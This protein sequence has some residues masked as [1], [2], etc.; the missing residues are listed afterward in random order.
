M[1]MIMAHSA[2][3]ATGIGFWGAARVAAVRSS[4]TLLVA[5]CSVSPGSSS[6]TS[7]TPDPTSITVPRQTGDIPSALAEPPSKGSARSALVPS[8]LLP[9]ATSNGKDAA[10]MAPRPAGADT[11][12]PPATPASPAPTASAGPE[13]RSS[14]PLGSSSVPGA[15]GSPTCDAAD[16]A[17][18]ALQLTRIASGLSEPTFAAAAPGDDTRL[19]VLERTG[20]IRVLRDGMLL[21][22]PFLNLSGRVLTSNESGLVGLAFHPRYADNGRFFVQYALL[23]P[24]QRVG[25]D[26]RV[27]LSEFRRSASNTD[28]ADA[29]SER[30][31][32]VVEQPA[33]M[34]LGGMLAFG[35]S[36]GML[37]VSRGEGGDVS[38]QDLHSLLG[39]MLRIDV[40]ATDEGRPYGIPAG[41]LRGDG[42]LPEIWSLGF[43]NP[44]RFA[45]DDCTNDIYIGDVGE[46]HV[47]ELDFEPANSP[48][49]NYG[50]NTLEGSRCFGSNQAC[51][52][53][54]FTPP[55]LE[56]EHA[57][58]G[59]AVIA[60]RVYRGQRIPALRG[61][62]LYADYCTGNFGSFRIQ[63]G[64]AVDARD[65]TADLNPGRIRYITSFG[66]D[67]SG[68][69]YVLTQLGDLYRIDPE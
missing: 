23:D 42:I 56:Y 12:S 43:R 15:A 8:A 11:T 45:F 55:V 9:A 18:P 1:L 67:N 54:G 52:R 69:L 25:D 16:G 14:P 5:G 30:E 28:Q 38:S 62:F 59:C 27:I 36:D 68:E 20:G 41:N 64:Q 24:S 3:P 35:P 2:G 21:P 47:E 4:A 13:G 34:H 53:A 48:G 32:M 6:T 57:D 66:V 19:F 61:T 31:L 58:F 17:L 33:D 46:D 7:A 40:D 60:G 26:H 50:W 44:W 10:P 63:N 65:M 51:V 49:R 29:G 37:Y 39:K 22:E